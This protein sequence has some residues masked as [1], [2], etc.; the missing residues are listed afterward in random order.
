MIVTVEIGTDDERLATNRANHLLKSLLRSRHP[1]LFE[2][3]DS[4]SF[5]DIW[6]AATPLNRTAMTRDCPPA[7]STGNFEN[8][9]DKERATVIYCLCSKYMKDFPSTHNTPLDPS[10]FTIPTPLR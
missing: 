8:L 5:V 2:N 7:F 1:K 4:E 10:L 9:T 3:S 6:L